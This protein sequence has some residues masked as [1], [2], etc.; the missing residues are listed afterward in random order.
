[1]LLEPQAMQYIRIGRLLFPRQSSGHPDYFRSGNLCKFGHFQSFA[2]T[3]RWPVVL[4]VDIT[5]TGFYPDV[6]VMIFLGVDGRRTYDA[7]ACEDMG[8][9]ISTLKLRPQHLPKR[10]VR[11]TGVDPRPARECTFALDTGR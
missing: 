4:N 1:M 3:Y 10:S 5:A 9:K 8:R 7:R 11:A 2:C 6:P